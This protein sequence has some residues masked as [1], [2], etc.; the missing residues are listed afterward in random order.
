LNGYSTSGIGALRKEFEGAELG[1]RRLEQRLL[2]VAEAVGA[3][4]ADSFP[5]ISGCDGEL[6]G[7]Y[8]FFSN[9]KVTA[10]AVLAPHYR[11]S[12]ARIQGHERVCV[13]RYVDVLVFWR[14][15][16]ARTWEA[17]AR[18]RTRAKDSIAI[19]LWR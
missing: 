16:S 5:D 15:A 4:P 14:H 12:V 19:L 13:A 8:R 9:K 7:L 10:S 3:A 2:R 17:S 1:D 6:E 11:E 18:G